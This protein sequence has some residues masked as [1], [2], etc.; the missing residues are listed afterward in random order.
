MSSSIG[1]QKKL[2][3][4]NLNGYTIY[5]PSSHKKEHFLWLQNGLAVV[6]YPTKSVSTT[7]SEMYKSVL[8]DKGKR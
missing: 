1:D 3:Y 7:I 5:R 6:G 8:R 2:F 4:L